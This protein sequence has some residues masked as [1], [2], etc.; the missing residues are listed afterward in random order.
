MLEANEALP[1]D[2]AEATAAI[3]RRVR[4]VADQAFWDSVAEGLAERQ[5]P[6]GP[7]LAAMQ[8]ARLHGFLHLQCNCAR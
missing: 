7:P 5:G 4:R 6:G 3:R 1:E 8:Q 2:Q